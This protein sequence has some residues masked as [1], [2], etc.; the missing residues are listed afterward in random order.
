MI[1]DEWLSNYQIELKEQHNL[2]SS[3]V[4]KLLQTFFDKER[5]VVHY[6]L[7]KLNVH[8]GLVIRKVHRLLQ[9]RQENWLSPY[10]TLN[11]EKRQVASNKFEE[12]FYK[13]INNV[14]YGKNCESKRRKNKTTVSRDAEHA[15]KIISKFEFDLYMIF[16]ENLAA[17]TARPK[18]IYWNT[19]TIVGATIL[20]LAKYHMY[21]FH[22]NVMRP[23][24]HCR[25]LYSD[26]DSLLYAINSDN[27][28]KELSQKPQ[29]VLSHFDFS[30]YPPNHFLYNTTYKRV[31]LKYRDEFVGDYITDFICLKPKLN[32]ILP[33]SK[34][35]LS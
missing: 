22:Y 11:S 4:K 14:V 34:F 7:L 15:L 35:I 26:R 19:P 8:L 1:E 16:G 25:L 3:K 29:S 20:D 12:N 31:D 23:N 33:K 30:N 6:K 27:F 13:L 21:A 2:P 32:S 18:S 28:Y 9:F 24:F 5:Y 17:L 10:I